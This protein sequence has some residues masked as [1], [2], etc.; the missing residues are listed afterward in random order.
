MINKLIRPIAHLLPENNTLE[1]I[2]VLAKVDFKSRYYYHRLGI[3]WAL[4][5]PM[6]ELLVYYTI[7]KSLFKSEI[8]NFALYLC[9][10][11]VIWYFFAEGTSK[12]I[13]ALLGK[14]YLIESVPFNKFHIILAA[15]ISASFSLAFNL[16]AYIIMSIILNAPPTWPFI[17][18]IP[19]IL[20]ILF[21]LVLGI[22]AI[23]ST[24]S[25]YLKDIQHLWDMVILA[26]F[27]ATPIVYSENL[28]YENMP[29]MMYL[30][31][32]APFAVLFHEVTLYHSQPSTDLIIQSIITSIVTCLIGFFIFN[33]FSHKAAEKL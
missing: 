22:S 1:R 7:F 14:R 23:L 26:G 10:G 27:W 12:G 24:L 15:T 4:I 2:W 25:I 31:P 20:I 9:G 17:L 13:S 32:V 19:L 16:L 33:R 5:R 3:L 30:N 8:E 29:Q 18:Y 28:I 21:L 11:L 6:I